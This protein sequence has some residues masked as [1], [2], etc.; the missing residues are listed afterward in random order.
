M[1]RCHLK[2]LSVQNLDPCN[3]FIFFR[4]KITDIFR[5]TNMYRMFH[6]YFYWVLP[7]LDRFTEYLVLMCIP[8]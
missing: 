6:L 4:E 1:D 3:K 8:E 7:K 2:F 5:Q